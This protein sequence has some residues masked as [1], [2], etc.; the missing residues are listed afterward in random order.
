MLDTKQCPIT[1]KTH[2]ELLAEECL[3]VSWCCRTPMSGGTL[4][5]WF[6]SYGGKLCPNCRS[7]ALIVQ[8]IRAQAKCPHTIILEDKFSR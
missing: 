4:N 5:T 3:V 7:E 2:A 1:L 8:V 6:R